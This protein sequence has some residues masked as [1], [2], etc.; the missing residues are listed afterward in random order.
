M[1]VKNLSALARAAGIIEGMAVDEKNGE[2]LMKVVKMLDA[3]IIDEERSKND[4]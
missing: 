2:R 3:V 1:K 4:E